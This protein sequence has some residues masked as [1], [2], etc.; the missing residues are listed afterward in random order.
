MNAIL[1]FC[2]YMTFV[3]LPFDLF[4]KPVLGDEEVW[5]GWILHGWAAK[6]TEP[7][8]WAIYAA[9]TLG[10]W[11]MHRWLHP[12]ASLYTAQI[13]LGMG[14]FGLVDPRSPGPVAAV[15][16]ALAFGALA[17][18]LWRSRWRFGPAREFH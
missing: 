4:W 5:F 14:V 9:G 3:Y 2:A 11:R 17:I 6:A 8:H 10:F 12:W 7:L 1:A 15:V 16:P 13:A 18:V